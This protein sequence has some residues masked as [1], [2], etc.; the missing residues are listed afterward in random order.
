VAE[1]GGV[2][3]DSAVV[4]S[5]L[6]KR[7]ELAHMRDKFLF[8]RA[9]PDDPAS[10]GEAI[11]LCGNSLGLQPR[12]ARDYVMYELDEWQKRGVEA[13]FLHSTFGPKQPSKKVEPWLTTDENVHA[14]AAKLVGAREIEVAI[15]NG[16]TVNL[17]LM[18]VPFYR[19]TPARHKILMESRPFPSDWVR[20]A[21]ELQ[22]GFDSLSN[23][24]VAPVRC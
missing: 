16:L 17:H 22:S 12:R 7:D 14:R 13:H 24:H 11:Y 2:E 9:H 18:M 10:S 6:D 4:A 8:P 20:Q 23:M 3:V 5:E 1:L 15:M 19:P 21:V